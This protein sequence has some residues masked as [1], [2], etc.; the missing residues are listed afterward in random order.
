M[1]RFIIAACAGL[2]AL[3][4]AP[5]S[6]ASDLP[7]PVYKAPPYKAPLY[8]PVPVF[9]WTGFYVG[10][11]GGYAWG[12]SDW[13][14]TTAM[15]STNPDGG[16]VGGT[17]GYNLQTG[18]WVWG[19]EGDISYSWI[20]GTAVGTGFCAG[21]GCQT[22]NRWFGTIRGRI[23]YAIDRWM[24]YITGGGAFGDVKMTTNTGASET[25]SRFGWTVGAGVEYAFLSPWT[26][27]VE[28]LYMDLGKANCSA[29]TCVVNT[30]VD[31]TASMVRAGFNYRF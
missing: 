9:S 16:L 23:G 2:L 6:L 22:E 3:A 8:S 11:V 26:F 31:F 25:D 29:A 18:N 15:G 7:P 30:D 13:S 10:I 1:R 24:P 20:K 4:M 17:L 5:P 21:A 27:K 28:Y 14:S 12:N 19:L